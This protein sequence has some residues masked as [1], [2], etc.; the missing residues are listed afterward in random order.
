MEGSV[1]GTTR[2]GER[3]VR[4]L[5]MWKVTHLQTVTHSVSALI[6]FRSEW[7]ASTNSPQGLGQL[8]VT[9]AL[10]IGV[11]TLALALGG[12]W[13]APYAT[14]STCTTTKSK[15]DIGDLGPGG[16]VVFLTP[17]SR[18][19]PTN[20]FFEVAPPAWKPLGTRRPLCDG[21]TQ[22][23]GT[24]R[25]V[26]AGRRNT[27]KIMN[28]PRC[29]SG[30]AADVTDYSGGG[31]RDWF[32]PS[33]DELNA[34]WVNIIEPKATRKD[35]TGPGSNDFISSS[36]NGAWVQSQ[37]MKRGV[38]SSG[39]QGGIMKYDYAYNYWPVRMFKLRGPPVAA[40]STPSTSPT[41]PKPAFD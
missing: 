36:A 22:M 17:D 20:K 26:G 24:K 41:K 12:L 28:W 6:D 25:G 32:L 5:Y 34:I 13:L 19:N 39:K 40:P 27:I 38:S 16:G 14:A 3:A 37:Y 8:M 21:P 30:A 7:R 2:D 4:A 9:K 33:A 18:G 35:W 1:P 31:L 15:C 29:T 10:L 23:N 11:T